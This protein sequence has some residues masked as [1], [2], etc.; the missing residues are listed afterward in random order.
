MARIILEPHE[1]FEHIHDVPSISQLIQ[2]KVQMSYNKNTYL[3]KVGHSL[4]IPSNTAHCM[5][6]LG[7]DIAIMNCAHSPPA[8]SESVAAD[9]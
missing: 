6:N 1:K 3:M 2:G 7:K 4:E 9:V 8:D 5:T